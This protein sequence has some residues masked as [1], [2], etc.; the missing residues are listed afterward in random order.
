MKVLIVGYGSIAKKHI[1]ALKSFPFDFEFYALRSKS[2]AKEIKGIISF[3]SWEELNVQLDFIIVSNPTINH[4]EAI[5]QAL[6]LNTPLFIEKPVLHSLAGANKLLE[7]ISK[8]GTKTYVACNLRFH[9]CIEYAKSIVDSKKWGKVQE[10]NVYCGSYLPDW[11]PGQDF[12]TAYSANKS[13]GGGVHLDLI[14][15][16]DY[17]YWMFGMPISTTSLLRNSSSLGIDAIDY[18]NYTLQYEGFVTQVVLNYFRK[19]AKRTLEIVS[20]NGTIEIDLLSNEVREN[21]EIT[22]SLNENGFLSTYQSQM[23]YFIY[24]VLEK[25]KEMNSFAEALNVLKICLNNEEI[26]K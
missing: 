26:R 8:A 21:K 10:V 18:A 14:H 25:G 24:E 22:L 4:Y 7:K 5:D 11:R 17:L 3:Y 12:R 20:E 19:D 13:M 1:E 6:K 9:A 16:L 2:D 23:S 15:E